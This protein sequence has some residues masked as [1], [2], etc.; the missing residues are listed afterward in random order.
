MH[1]KDE[2]DFINFALEDKSVSLI[3][4]PRWPN[5]KPLTTRSLNSI[6]SYYCIIWS[7]TDFPHTYSKFIPE[8]GDWYCESEY[9]TIQFLRSEATETELT[10]GRLAVGTNY[11]D[12]HFLDEH[13]KAIEKRFRLYSKYIKKIFLN[14][15]AYWYNSKSHT[16]LS[17]PIP[18]DVLGKPDKNLWVGP[19]ALK[20]LENNNE[21]RIRQKSS[22]SVACLKS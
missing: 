15:I 3:N 5:E 8:R 10:V 20:W 13:A 11:R 22:F 9:A 17:N 18:P 16:P 4:G 2:I 19:Y 1:P 12:E 6:N 21:R 7:K 14:S